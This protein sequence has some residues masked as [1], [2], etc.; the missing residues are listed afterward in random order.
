VQAFAVQ[1]IW[2]FEARAGNVWRQFLRFQAS[3]LFLGVLGSACVTFLDRAGVH[4]LMGQAITIVFLAAGGFVAGRHFT[5][6]HDD[7]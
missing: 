6:K 3:Y 4:P 1:R 7:A 2:V 5:F